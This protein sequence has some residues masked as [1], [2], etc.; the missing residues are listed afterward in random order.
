MKKLMFLMSIC[1]LTTT[2]IYACDICGANVH[3][4]TS[5]IV[6]QLNKTYIGLSGSY[7]SYG[8]DAHDVHSVQHYYTLVLAGQYQATRKLVINAS[9]P[10]QQINTTEESI[11]S[12]KGLGDASIGLNYQLLQRNK[13]DNNHVLLIGAGVKINTGAYSNTKTNALDEL[14]FQAGSGSTDY[15]LNAVYVYANRR[16]TLS[17]SAS[18]KYNTPNEDG[19]RF[20]DIITTAVTAA[21]SIS[22]AKAGIIPYFQLRND[23]QLMNAAAHTLQ[24][25][26][27]G[28]ALY[29][30]AGADMRKDKIQ[31]G[32]TGTFAPLQNLANGS[33]R[34]RPSF[35]ASIAYF[36]I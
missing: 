31:L 36:L 14:N 25:G 16:L 2:A 17:G 18:Y 21:Y 11:P 8:F 15:L 35:T 1:M 7:R 6:P 12:R 19:F 9:L 10:Y 4:G 3:S 13:G 32:I 27:G 29:A 23:I 30:A 5:S 26:T 24:N 34:V 33:V 20:G 28:Y 22:T